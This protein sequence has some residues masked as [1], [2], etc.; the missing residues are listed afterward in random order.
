[1]ATVCF[2]ACLA[3]HPALRR[4]EVDWEQVGAWDSLVKQPEVCWATPPVQGPLL[5]TG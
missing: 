2:P 5:G 3:Q 1:M 4:E